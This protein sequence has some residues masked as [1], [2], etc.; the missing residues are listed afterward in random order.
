MLGLACRARKTSIGETCMHAVT[1]RKAYVVFLANDAGDNLTKK[2]TDKKEVK[3]EKKSAKK[4]WL[5]RLSVASIRY[6]TGSS[7]SL[8]WL[9]YTLA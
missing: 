4:L 9:E 8:E 3:E 7:L 2:T 1:S 6:F 5:S